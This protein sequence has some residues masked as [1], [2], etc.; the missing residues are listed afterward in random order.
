MQRGLITLWISQEVIDNWHPEAPEQRS[1]DGQAPYSDQAIECVLLM[2]AVY[3]LPYRQSVGFT[4]SVM[5]MLG[6]NVDVADYTTVCKRSVELSVEL[7]KLYQSNCCFF[8]I[9][10]LLMQQ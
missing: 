5:E 9:H 2:R 6:A 4:Q 7:A 10:V 8:N 3:H 1:R